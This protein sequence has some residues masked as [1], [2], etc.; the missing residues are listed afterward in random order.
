MIE[1]NWLSAALMITAGLSFTAA[2][3]FSSGI[4]HD[5]EFVK[6]QEQHGEK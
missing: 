2:N 3:R 5:A 1:R 4:I 6:L